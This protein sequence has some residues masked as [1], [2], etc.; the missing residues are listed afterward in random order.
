MRRCEG[1][2]II[3]LVDEEIDSEMMGKLEDL[4]MIAV[5]FTG[6]DHIDIG[7]AEKNDIAVVNVPEYATTSVAEL[8][9]GFT[10][11]LLRDIRIGDMVVRGKNDADREDIKGNELG[12]KKLGIIGT[13]NIG[14]KVA[15]LGKLFGMD[16]IAYSRS[17]NSEIKDFVN[18]MDMDD[19]FEE[20]DIVSL[21][22]P[23]TDETEGVIGKSEL[24]KM[25]EGSILINTARAGVIDR[26]A[27]IESV[28]EGRI[29]FGIDIPHDDL[30]K[31]VLESDN[32]LY[33]P[34]VGYYT[35]EALKRRLEITV[36]NIDK[37]IEGKRQNR[38]V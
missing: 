18:Y 24:S 5:S 17:K 16:V 21:N 36:D 10:I 33:T 20:S 3:V 6:Y 4:E 29:R 37:F 12:G 8:V 25:S 19:V 13:G 11:N 1:S 38:I 23:L 9:F 22:I 35:E 7:Y 28:K 27:F 14:S 34:H 31:D 2:E 15:E 30:P 32:V 26:E